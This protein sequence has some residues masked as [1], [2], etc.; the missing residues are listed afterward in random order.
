MDETLVMM[1]DYPNP[2][3]DVLVPRIDVKAAYRDMLTGVNTPE[4]EYFY[5][6]IGWSNVFDDYNDYVEKRERL[7]D[8]EILSIKEDRE[9]RI[10]LT[11]IEKKDDSEEAAAEGNNASEKK[12]IE[13]N[14]E[15]AGDDSSGKGG[16]KAKKKKK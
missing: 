1:N 12:T 11:T 13:T 3:M 2:R 8:D 15:S 14:V 10:H 16:K 6:R 9:Q 7:T 5:T 4:E